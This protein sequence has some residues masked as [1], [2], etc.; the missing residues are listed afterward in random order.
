M[1]LIALALL[2]LSLLVLLYYAAHAWRALRNTGQP[3]TQRNDPRHRFLV[4]IPAHDE[5]RE[6]AATV[7]ACR[8][9]DYPA[10]LFRVLVIA[11]NCTDDTA[12][13]ARSAGAEVLER[14][15]PA[16]P[17]KGQALAWA[18]PRVL[19]APLDAVVV[20][21][22]DCSLERRALR[23]LDAHLASGARVLQCSYQPSN[24]DAGAISYMAAVGSHLE[25]ALFYAGKR[26]DQAV[27]LRGTGMVFH[28]AVLEALPWRA[29]SLAE[30]SEHSLRLLRA[31]HRV[32]FLPDTRVQ[33]PS[34]VDAQQLRVQRSRWAQGNLSLGRAQAAALWLEGLRRRQRPLRDAALTLLT[35]SRPLVLLLYLAA[36]LCSLLSAQPA[37][38]LMALLVGAGYFAYLTAGALGLGLSRRRLALLLASPPALIQLTLISVAGLRRRNLA[39]TRTP[40]G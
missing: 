9:L 22:A 39:W 1:T 24:P 29:Q 33:S 40:R 7:R 31:G 17:G 36:L 30:D 20:L 34:A 27:L 26:P 35:L 4:L 2:S 38:I 25:N 14:H 23:S 28:R 15:D 10:A 32:V 3:P 11:D 5:R 16:R 13:R 6:I 37:L 18:L 21:D 12:E 19:A 8:A